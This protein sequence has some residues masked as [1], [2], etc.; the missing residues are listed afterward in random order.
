[1]KNKRLDLLHIIILVLVRDNPK[2]TS[3]RLAQS[4]DIAEFYPDLDAKRNDTLAKI[5]NVLYRLSK[6]GLLK[7]SKFES[8]GIKDRD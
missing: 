4:P 7:S 1:M 2:I 6:S 8:D 5:S 3:V